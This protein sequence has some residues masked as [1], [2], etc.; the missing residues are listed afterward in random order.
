MDL[1]EKILDGQGTLQDVELIEHTA[2]IISDSADC[3]IGFQAANHVL[4]ALAAFREDFIAHITTG[5][6]VASYQAVP[7]AAQCP[8]HV[9]IPGYIALVGE[10]RYAD[11]VHLIRKDNPFPSA[12]ALICEHPCE[13]HCRRGVVDDAVNIR[14]LKRYAV[15]NAGILPPPPSA[16]ATGKTVAIIGGGPSGLSAAYYLQIMGHSVTVFE[17]RQKLGGMLRY[18]IPN[19]RLPDAYL[20]AD[21][22]AILATGVEVRLNT[23]IGS[24]IS[25]EDVRSQ[26]DSVYI[27]IGA[28][29]D[30]KLGIEGEQSEGVISAV[31]LLSNMGDGKR[32]DFSGKRVIIVG[33]GNVAMDAARTSI[34]LGAASVQCAYRRRVNDMTALPAEIEGAMAEGVEMVQLVAPVRVEQ[35]EHN[36]VTALVVQPQIVGEYDQA[37]R[38]RPLNAA[39]EPVHMPCDIII[40]A[41]GQA[42][43][44][45]HFGELG[46]PTKW[47]MI[48]AD[49]AAA[50]AGFP[51]V[52]AGGDCAS[53]PATVILAI[54]AGKVAAANIDAYLGFN[55][56]I[57]QEI[58]IPHASHNY[59]RAS[60]RVNMGERPAEERRTD[61][62]LM[63]LCLT[64]Q[65]A[66]HEC[67]RC[68]RC[69]H[70]GFGALRGGRV[71]TW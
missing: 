64:A 25:F 70:F 12:C 5:Q 35:N 44:S 63:E 4:S 18:G 43:V 46:I 23:S 29:A 27:T 42:I 61:F 60:G 54:E 49:R 65:E 41:I 45:Q 52:F 56:P 50:V 36:Q 66:G 34:R 59:R 69:D 16:P 14:A 3:A 17:K 62:E 9:D 47:D 68:L 33:G 67:A 8:A 2:D 55:H 20:D 38:P 37:G 6:C 58:E 32:P 1:L 22:D 24:E 13:H 71:A 57:A 39:K 11:A 28:H 53:G 51:G 7:C 40:V 10:K 15:D 19:Y 21:I 26:F 31:E 48:Q 30:R